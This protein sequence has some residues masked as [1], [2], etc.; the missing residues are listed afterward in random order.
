MT[1]LTGASFGS[2]P[3]RT[4]LKNKIE[5][6]LRFLFKQ[7]GYNEIALPVY[8]YYSVLKNTGHRFPDEHLISFTDISSG[9]LLVLRPDFTPQVSRLVAG[10]KDAFPLPIRLSYGGP[11]FRNAD[12][13]HGAKAEKYHLGC[14]LYG[15]PEKDGDKELLLLAVSAARAALADCM[16]IIGDAAYLARLRSLL[17]DYAAEY[18]D[19]LKGKKLYKNT[20]FVSKLSGDRSVNPLL[21]PLIAELPAIFGGIQVLKR[22]KELS[23]FDSKLLKRADYLT[24]LFSEGEELGIAGDALLFDAAEILDLN[25]YTGLTLELFHRESGVALGSGGRYDSLMNTFNLTLNACG[26][27]LYLEELADVSPLEDERLGVDY[28]VLGDIHKAEELRKSGHTV[29]LVH[30][31]EEIDAFLLFSDAKNV[32]N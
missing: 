7:Y 4:A 15:A 11:V 2:A 17:G 18:F 6:S 14:E 27:S 22:L 10:Y 26:L 21:L 16:L 9:R 3:K 28:L 12:I 32:I 1:L 23:A 25:Y 20:E 30:S 31:K 29:A 8:E 24:T 13:Q 5:Q 19:I